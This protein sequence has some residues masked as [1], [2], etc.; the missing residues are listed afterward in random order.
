MILY[1]I[2][3]GLTSFDTEIS[4]PLHGAAPG[5]AAF[6]LTA[7]QCSIMRMHHVFFSHLFVDV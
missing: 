4:R 1:G 6:F 5:S 7:E 3:L 2:C